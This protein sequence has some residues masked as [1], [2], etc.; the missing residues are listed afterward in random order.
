MPS[1]LTRAGAVIA[2]K[3]FEETFS[4]SDAS[5]WG[6]Q[7]VTQYVTSGGTLSVDGSVARLT[8]GK[9]SI[10]DFA[11]Q[12]AANR[13]DHGTVQF[14]F[15]VPADVSDSR[16]YW[17]VFQGDDWPFGVEVYQSAGSTW[18]A[19]IYYAYP[20]VSDPYY[21]FTPAANSWYRVKAY[22][23]GVAD[24]LMAVKVWRVGDAE[25]G[26]QAIGGIGPDAVP[27]SW[28]EGWTPKTIMADASAPTAEPLGFDN[29]IITS[30][31]P[32]WSEVQRS[33]LTAGAVIRRTMSGSKTIDASIYPRRYTADAW[34]IG[35]RGGHSRFYDH[36]GTQPD[37]VIVIDGPVGPFPSGT[38]LHTVLLDI[39]GRIE[40]LEGG[41]HRTFSFGAGA[42]IQPRLSAG[43]VIFRPGTTHSLTSDAVIVGGK[44]NQQVTADALIVLTPGLAFSADAWLIDLVC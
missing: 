8:A 40:A 30:Y 39:V 27:G 17:W 31:G 34:I 10:V 28:Y 7:F 37:T 6:P 14:D 29:L 16:P 11:D 38:G 41:F 20:S 5:G 42:F 32:G 44:T 36:Y 23:N 1:G 33:Q 24:G 43:A 22:I 25:P 21:S 26:W 2:K 4:F 18:D 9:K 12:S 13:I 3:I 15:W 19:G 35:G